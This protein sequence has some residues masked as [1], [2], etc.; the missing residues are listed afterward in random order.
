V[1]LTRLGKYD[2]A[3]RDLEAASQTLRDPSVL[4]HLARAY[5]K[6]GKPDEARK[7]RDRALEAGLGRE[8]LQQSERAD[9][10][11]VMNPS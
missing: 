3:V 9:W 7:Y 8:Q 2:A 10:D 1:I 11:A 4:Y 6:M 5:L